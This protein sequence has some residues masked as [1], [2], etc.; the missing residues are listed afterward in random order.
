MTAELSVSLA[1]LSDFSPV[2]A[3][4]LPVGV[5]A[6]YRVHAGNWSQGAADGAILRVRPIA[7]LSF[8]LITCAGGGGAVCPA[9]SVSP[10]QL[11][12][13]LAISRFP[14]DSFVSVELS[15]TVTGAVGS[16]ARF[17]I[18]V[19]PPA[20][21]I[22][23]DSSNNS[24]RV[25]RTIVASGGGASGRPLAGGPAIVTGVPGGTVT[26][27]PPA[28]I[29]SDLW[30]VD[31]GVRGPWIKGQPAQLGGRMRNLGPA[32]V[33][34]AI[35][36][37]TMPPSGFSITQMQCS[38]PQDGPPVPCP[39]IAQLADGFA[40]PTL[41]PGRQFRIDISGTVTGDV[42]SSLTFAMTGRAPTGVYDPDSTNNAAGQTVVIGGP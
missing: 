6:R 32:P 3:D 33:T 14:A 9:S 18:D 2:P 29:T 5:T 41:A 17:D 15:A 10:G 39:T 7:G 22:D 8:G 1:G 11:E 34:G 35:L 16:E 19:A 24:M 4:S 26:K 23:P 12:S 37:V 21:V 42:G 36:T 13:G 25:S 30:T 38:G 40:T 20:S 27:E 31:N 28:G